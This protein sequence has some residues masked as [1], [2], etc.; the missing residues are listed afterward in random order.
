MIIK[1]RITNKAGKFLGSLY[2]F[3]GNFY[4]PLD[5]PIQEARRVK[6]LIKIFL[7]KNKELVA[8]DRAT[9]EYRTLIEI[10]DEYYN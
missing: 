2:Y 7:K 6:N 10:Y 5:L 4:H 3:E 8:E 9:P 1:K